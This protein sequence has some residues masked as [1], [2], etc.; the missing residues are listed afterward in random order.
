MKRL[1]AFG[2]ALGMASVGL[3]MF[4]GGCAGQSTDEAEIVA[5]FHRQTDASNKEDIEAYMATLDPG[6]P[7]IESTRNATQLMF[8]KY[9]L[10]MWVE[11]AKVVSIK[12]DT[13]TARTTIITKKIDGDAFRNN[14]NQSLHQLRKVSGEWKLVSSKPEDIR[15]LP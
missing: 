9:R 15:F 14:R 6:A 5:L 10:N 12:G 13:A 3:A 2:P 8:D 1:G 4:L 11:D 7:G